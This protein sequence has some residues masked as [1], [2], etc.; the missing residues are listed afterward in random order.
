MPL[1]IWALIKDLFLVTWCNSFLFIK[2]KKWIKHQ[3]SSFKKI[4][5]YT[6][7]NNWNK[8]NTWKQRNE[9]TK[10]EAHKKNHLQRGG[11]SIHGEE[12][13]RKVCNYESL[14]LCLKLLPFPPNEAEI[15]QG[16]MFHKNYRNYAQSSWIKVGQI[17]LIIIFFKWLNSCLFLK[18]CF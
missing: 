6:H 15:L 2:A 14:F 10:K 18:H 9:G 11:D 12:T 5:I 13:S 7:I 1:L 3:C 4:Y 16:K 17:G 8:G